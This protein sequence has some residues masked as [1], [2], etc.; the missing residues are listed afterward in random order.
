MNLSYYEFSAPPSDS[1]SLGYRVS[2]RRKRIEK[3]PYITFR[4]IRRMYVVA[5]V[6]RRLIYGRSKLSAQ[7]KDEKDTGEYEVCK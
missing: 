6:E 4:A 3:K 7:P 2:E 5:T 1:L